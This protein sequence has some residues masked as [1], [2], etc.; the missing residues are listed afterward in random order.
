[1]TARLA[2]PLAEMVAEGRCAISVLFARHQRMVD[3]RLL[4]HPSRMAPHAGGSERKRLLVSPS[5]EL[6]SLFVSRESK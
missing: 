3:A 2:P 4:G 6:S 5:L 1:M